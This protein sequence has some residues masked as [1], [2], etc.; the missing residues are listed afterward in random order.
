MDFLTLLQGYMDGYAVVIAIGLTQLI[1]YILPSQTGEG[2][3]S[4]KKEINRIM[5]FVP[6][7][8]AI[9]VVL[10]KDHFI[11]NGQTPVPWDDAII[12]GMISGFAAVYLYRTAKVTILGE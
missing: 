6:L 4:V 2:K 1:K 3:W 10:I 9:A 11:C 8:L 5:P 7:I 12:K